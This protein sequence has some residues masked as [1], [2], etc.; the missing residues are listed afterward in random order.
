MVANTTHNEETMKVALITGTSGGIGAAVAQCLAQQGYSLYLAY[1]KNQAQAEVVAQQCRHLG[2]PVTT[3]ACDLSNPTESETIVNDCVSRYGKVTAL[4]HCAGM[5]QESLLSTLDDATL[6]ALIAVHVVS[7]VALTRTA[8]R[9]MLLQRMGRIV[10]MSSVHAQKPSQ[11]AA[12]YAGCK[13]FVESFVRAMAVEVG[14]KGVTVNA[15]APGMIDTKMTLNTKA[16]LGEKLESRC[17]VK[18][19]GLPDEVARAV[20]FLC[21]ADSAYVTG[22]VLAV[23]GGYLGPP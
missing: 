16:L 14:R 21:R 17:A 20:E 8:L 6:N 11:G 4:V 9:S 23:D 22:Q 5:A 12:V 15:V 10:L 19:L 2:V 1:G 3:R 18:R 7:T 13:G